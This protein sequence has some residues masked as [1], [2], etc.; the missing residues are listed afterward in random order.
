MGGGIKDAWERLSDQEQLDFL[1][2]AIEH[3]PEPW[4]NLARQLGFE[5]TGKAFDLN[6]AEQSVVIQSSRLRHI[7][8]T[9]WEQ[10]MGDNGSGTRGKIVPIRKLVLPNRKIEVAQIALC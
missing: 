3:R 10:E 7:A 1:L 9:C 4:Q 6:L 2:Y 5:N 8:S